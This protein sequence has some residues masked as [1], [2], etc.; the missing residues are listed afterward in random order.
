MYWSLTLGVVCSGTNIICTGAG[1]A[2]TTTGA[3]AAAG[4]GVAGGVRALGAADGSVQLVW[5]VLA[6]K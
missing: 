6:L 3:A 5:L 4:V 2:A 1:D